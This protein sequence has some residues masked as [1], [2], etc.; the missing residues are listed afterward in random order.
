[1][2]LLRQETKPTVNINEDRENKLF[3]TTK[4]AILFSNIYAQYDMGIWS[5]PTKM[6]VT[7][8]ST[9][10]LRYMS[11]LRQFMSFPCG[12]IEIE[13]L[14]TAVPIPTLIPDAQATQRLLISNMQFSPQ[15]HV[16]AGSSLAKS[17]IETN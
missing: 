14:S 6:Y 4:C 5:I 17:S 13:G 9:I 12:T 1:M 11:T 15:P 16:S 3:V 8:P 7:G 10:P 2:A